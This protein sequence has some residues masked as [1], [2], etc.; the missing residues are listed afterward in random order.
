V[1]CGAND[2]G[3]DWAIVEYEGAGWVSIVGGET[4]AN[5]LKHM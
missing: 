4:F 2:E 3:Y 5:A 1:A